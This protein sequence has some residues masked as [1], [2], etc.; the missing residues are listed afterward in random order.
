VSRRALIAAAVLLTVVAVVRIVTTYRVFAQTVDEPIHVACG[1]Q[2]LATGKYDLDVEHPPLP[3]VLFALDA[4]LG[5]LKMNAGE[6]DAAPGTVDGRADRVTQGNVLLYRGDRYLRNLAGARAGN[7]PWFLLATAMVFVWGNRLSGPG[8]GVIAMA[9]FGA[10]P[11]ILAHAGLATTDMPVTATVITALWFFRLWLEDP[12]RKR[13]LLLGAAIGLGCVSKFS[14]LM[15]FPVGAL[16]LLIPRLRGLDYKR[17]LGQLAGAGVVA[18]L[19]IWAAYRF[20]HGLLYTTAL[21]AMPQGTV[22]NSAARYSEVPGYEWVRPD[23]VGRYHDYANLCAAQGRHGVDFVDWAKAAGFSSPNAGRS[24]KDTMIGAPPLPPIPLDDRLKEPFRRV[25]HFVRRHVPLPAITFF[26][27]VEYV[28]LHA[29]GGHAAYLFG[30]RNETGWWYY[31]PVVF[32]F[33]TPLAFLALA[34]TGIVVL[35]RRPEAVAWI[36]P[37]MLAAAMLTRINIGVRHVLPMYPFVAI[38]AAV[39]VMVV[40]RRSRVVAGALLLWFFAAGAIAHPDYL[41]HF[42]E[43]AGREPVRIAADSNLDWGQDLLRL[44]ALARSE[45]LEPLHISY[46]GST[47]AGAHIPWSKPLPEGVCTPGWVAVSETSRVMD[48]KNQFDWL[49]PFP[50]RTV[51]AS[52]RLYNV[53]AS[54]CAGATLDP[55]GQH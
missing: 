47:A 10:L 34:V 55:R 43:A 16:V 26:A 40:W 12:S 36:A 24:G 39:G 7:L 42:N 4:W 23:L 17:R 32:F 49:R 30:E 27:G 5:G 51:G 35:A 33:K 31:F 15:Y 19:M 21:H 29:S 52:I 41:A 14:F 1:F 44:A 48:T 46:F 20:E 22:E 28:R 54:A 45:R 6:Q 2:W 53:P 25:D 3:R 38:A 11:P 9:L 13:T 8:T 37:A 50:Y 18:F